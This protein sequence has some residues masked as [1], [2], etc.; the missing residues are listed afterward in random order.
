M[1]TLAASTLGVSAL[2]GS[3]FAHASAMP[4]ATLVAGVENQLSVSQLLPRAPAAGQISQLLPEGGGVDSEPRQQVTVTSFRTVGEQSLPSPLFPGSYVQGPQA[5]IVEAAAN[6]YSGISPFFGAGQRIAG[7][8]GGGEA[9]PAGQRI[10]Y[11][12][13]S[14]DTLWSIAEKHLPATA[15][16]AEIFDAVRSIQLSNQDS[17]PTLDALIFPGQTIHF[18]L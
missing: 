2:M 13:V 11:T 16:G 14:G 12:V 17:I 7:G 10:T 1:K 15:S 18:S 5:L 3:G 4:E 6:S 8:S 9:G